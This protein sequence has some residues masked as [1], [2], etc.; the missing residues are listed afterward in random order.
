LR[1]EAGIETSPT[2]RQVDAVPEQVFVRDGDRRPV[3]QRR[4]GPGF[5]GFLERVVGLVLPGDRGV[6]IDQEELAD[7]RGRFAQ[8]FISS[9]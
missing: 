6:V 2:R 3:D 7:V 8:S 1:N 5:V 9:P 4:V